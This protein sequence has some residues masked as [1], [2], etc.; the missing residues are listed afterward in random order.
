MAPARPPSSATNH[1]QMVQTVM[2]DWAPM[3]KFLIGRSCAANDSSERAVVFNLWPPPR[4]RVWGRGGQGGWEVGGAAAGVV[5]G[6]RGGGGR[7]RP[8]G[9]WVARGGGGGRRP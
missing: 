7:R 3:A 1:G 2:T 8:L 9:F 6:G 4:P 5:A